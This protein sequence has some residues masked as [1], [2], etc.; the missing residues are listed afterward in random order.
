MKNLTFNQQCAEWIENLIPLLINL[1]IPIVLLLI[2]SALKYTVAKGRPQIL[3][4]DMS[5]EVPIDFLCVACTLVITNFIF[6]GNTMVGL[7]TGVILLLL[8]ILV[9]W[10]GCWLRVSVL[11]LHKE[12]KPSNKRIYFAIGLY[13]LVIIWLSLVLWISNV[14]SV[15]HE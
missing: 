15:N 6:H 10:F 11:E 8:T 1:I 14:L 4:I 9:A 13:A 7:V 5:V 12:H 2:Y 3:W